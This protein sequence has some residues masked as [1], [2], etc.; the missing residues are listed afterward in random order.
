MK[1]TIKYIIIALVFIT[2]TSKLSP[3]Y[4]INDWCDTNSFFT[5][6][7]AIFNGKIIYR[8]LFEQKG[9]ILYLIYGIGYLISN[10]TFI[11]VYLLEI[12]SFGF[13]LRIV[14]K[15]LKVLEKKNTTSYLLI[16][17]FITTTSIAFYGGGSAEEFSLPYISW[18]IYILIKIIKNQNIKAKDQIKNGI[19]FSLVFLI[20][21]NLV[22]FW[23]APLIIYIYKYKKD[24]IKGIIYFIIGTLIPILITGLYF[25][26]NN[27]L[28]EFIDV[29]F[30]KNIFEYNNSEIRIS[31]IDRFLNG[32]IHMFIENFLKNIF[33][34]ITL[35]L[36]F[37]Y[38][39]KNKILKPYILLMIIPFI[40]ICCQANFFEYYI[41]PFS[42]LS[43]FGLIELFDRFKID[44]INKKTLLIILIIMTFINGKNTYMLKYKKQD[45]A[46]YNF[47]KIINKYED[48]SVLNYG[49]ID[50]GFYLETNE[51]PNIR[52]FHTMNFSD[53]KEMKEEQL[54]YINN[55]KTNFVI[56]FTIKPEQN[57]NNEEYIKKKYKLITMERHNKD[58][59]L[60]YYL[61]IRK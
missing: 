11:G 25:L 30:L 56:C 35:I 1:K 20:K 33:L 53:F 28:Y 54:S 59:G 55:K 7:K 19:C 58:Y 57:C 49:F 51:V 5:M 4:P 45:Y 29:Y 47:T 31:F 36:S 32:L 26:I 42:I 3:I 50:T 44:K 21:F 40:L 34:I 38:A 22:S 60:Y 10:K 14:D 39:K 8:D 52:F 15:I 27:S 9:P 17:S 41:L 43:L 48:K 23:I 6:G 18:C 61:Y 13:F 12:L 37:I 24:A 16:I 2:I 46:Q